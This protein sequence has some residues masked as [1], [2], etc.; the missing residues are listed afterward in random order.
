MSRAKIEATLQEILELEL[1]I[2]KRMW[3]GS[4]E[5]KDLDGVILSEK[6]INDRVNILADQLVHDYPKTA[7]VLVSIL[8]G[9]I[10][11][12]NKLLDALNKRNYSYQFTTMQVSSYNGTSSGT[13]SVGSKPKIL[14]GGRTVIVLDEV[15]D[16]GK[17][18]KAVRD[19]FLE[20]GAKSVELM[21]LVD[22]I[23]KRLDHCDPKY[24]GFIVD[25]K[26]FIIG[27]GLDYNE[28]IRNT[29]SVRTAD[30]NTLPTDQERAIISTKNQLNEQLR[31]IIKAEKAAKELETN[32]GNSFFAVDSKEA[33]KNNPIVI[34][35]QSSCP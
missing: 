11:F 2:E 4:L 15:C 28:F 34:Q 5:C 32:K 14:L 18:Y 25:H 22:K 31:A 19:M 3:A 24:S 16:T 9:A 29:S 8:D 7:P 35:T 21:V 26:A 30:L 17:T 1:T 23:Q 13:V 20:D 33:S 12:T 27:M 6:N 10:P